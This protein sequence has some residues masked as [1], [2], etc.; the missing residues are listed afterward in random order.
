[1]SGALGEPKSQ[2][3]ASPLQQRLVGRSLA[4]ITRD[5]LRSHPQRRIANINA[6]W[7]RPPGP[8]ASS[9]R[10]NLPDSDT[11]RRR[12]PMPQH[13]PSA[14]PRMARPA[15]G[16]RAMAH[17]HSRRVIGHLI[18]A[19]CWHQNHRSDGSQ[20]LPPPWLGEVPLHAPRAPR[21]P[22]S[23]AD[24]ARDDGGPRAADGTRSSP[25]VH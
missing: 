6:L 20:S 12:S 10:R 15:K 4:S 19:A 24:T 3:H 5:S 9:P 25:S 16:W 8:W 21:A 14:R 1:M 23:E 13:R 22:D 7:H 11:G 2:V 17:C 18:V